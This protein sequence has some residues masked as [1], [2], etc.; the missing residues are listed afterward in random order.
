ML[1]VMCF[2]MVCEVLLLRCLGSARY[3]AGLKLSR[4]V[5]TRLYTPGSVSYT[6]LRNGW[7]GFVSGIQQLTVW[8]VG[9]W[10]VLVILAAAALVVRFVRRRTRK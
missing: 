7:T 6:H 3:F 5:T 10:P 8:V 4:R 2:F 9:V 1:R